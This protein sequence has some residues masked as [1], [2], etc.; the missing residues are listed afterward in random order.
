[1]VDIDETGTSSGASTI[2][3]VEM[4]R[5][6]DKLKQERVRSTT[7][8]NYYSIWKAFNKFFLKLDNKPTWEERLVL[9]AGYLVH[10]SKQ[11][12]MVCSYISAIKNILQDD[13]VFRWF[14]FTLKP[15][16]RTGSERSLSAIW[17]TSHWNFFVKFGLSTA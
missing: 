2:S 12:Q 13:G 3:T 15:P 7:K 14:K 16:Y 6:I 17:D 8:S 1:M 10:S 4:H 9:Y 11:S 5:I